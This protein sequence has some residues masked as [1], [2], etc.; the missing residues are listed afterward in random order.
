MGGGYSQ[1][2]PTPCITIVINGIER[3]KL[4]KSMNTYI[5]SGGGTATPIHK[6]YEEIA[7]EMVPNKKARITYTTH[8][9]KDK[10][11]DPNL[12]VEIRITTRTSVHRSASGHYYVHTLKF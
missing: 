2:K 5:W 1:L 12:N 9:A 4:Y 8:A 11:F 7:R 10:M 3:F 6:T